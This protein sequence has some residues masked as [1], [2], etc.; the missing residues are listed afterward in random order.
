MWFVK[1]QLVPRKKK[2]ELRRDQPFGGCGT[3][4]QRVVS[5]AVEERQLV[6]WVSGERGLQA[7]RKSSAK[8][9]RWN[10]SAVH[11]E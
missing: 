1:K 11:W 9:Q 6:R 10:M 7:E 8:A 3:I 4:L 5:M 2:N